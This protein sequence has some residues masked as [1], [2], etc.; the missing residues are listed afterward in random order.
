MATIKQGI[1]GAF[2]GKVGSVVG[3]S[4]KGIAI[5]KA[6]PASVA[7]PKTAK[8]VIQRSKMSSAVAFAK[9]VLP[10]V[11][12]PLNDR[13]VSRMSGYNSFIQN[14]I[15]CFEGGVLTKPEDLQISPRVNKAQLIDAIAAEAGLYK[16]KATFTSDAGEGFALAT[17][18][19]YMV[20]HSRETG[21]VW[22]H[23]CEGVRADGEVVFNV[24]ASVDDKGGEIDYWF[25]FMRADGTVVFAT[26][27]IMEEI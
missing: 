13:F 15:N 17:D 18:V 1:L 7:N 4:W 20:G 21:E 8:Q 25:S 11:I 3:S 23:K 5:M 16:K 9:E 6:L 14:N 2:S 24:P 12:K 26:S 27:H 10:Q 22:G 19:C